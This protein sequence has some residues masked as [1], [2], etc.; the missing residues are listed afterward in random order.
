VDWGDDS[1]I[2]HFDPGVDFTQISHA[3]ADGSVERTITAK[4]PSWS[5]PT[6]TQTL[7]V[8]VSNVVPTLALSGD[9][10]VTEGSLYTLNL[11]ASD[12]G[13]DSSGS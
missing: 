11:S 2:Q 13:T 4:S 8:T 6:S 12:P 3:Y 7:D 1:G 10:S 9:A 5:S